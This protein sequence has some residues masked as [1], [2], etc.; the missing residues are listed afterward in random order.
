MRAAAAVQGSS[1]Y[2]WCR[3]VRD[4]GHWRSLLQPGRD[5]LRLVFSFPPSLGAAY[6]SLS[7]HP[8]RRCSRGGAEDARSSCPK[9]L[10]AR[11]FEPRK[12][13]PLF[14]QTP[15]ERLESRPS[16]PGRRSWGGGGD[17]TPAIKAL[18]PVVTIKKKLRKLKT[19]G[20]GGMKNRNRDDRACTAT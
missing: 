1:N 16:P 17:S 5:T 14:S 4:N 11:L 13:F 15:R 8:K 9:I 12:V 20:G 7:L 19:S 3:R 18:S 2:L 6:R 10:Y